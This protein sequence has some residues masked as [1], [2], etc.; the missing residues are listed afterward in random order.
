MGAR[1]RPTRAAMLRLAVIAALLI[2]GTRAYEVRDR[3]EEKS[4]TISTTLY[5]LP[6]G[7]K[8]HGLILR[9]RVIKWA[10]YGVSAAIG[11][12]VGVN[13]LGNSAHRADFL[14]WLR[15]VGGRQPSPP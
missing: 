1:L 13:V 10:A 14:K 9:R 2:C 3:N 4:K 5:Q 7:E 15:N 8:D 11:V 6:P 12:G